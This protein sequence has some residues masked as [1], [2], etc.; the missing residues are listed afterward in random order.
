MKKGTREKP[1][2]VLV[3]PTTRRRGEFLSAVKRSRGLHR[4]WASPSSTREAFDSY[5]K[6]LKGP[7]SIGYWVRTPEDELAGVINISEVVRGAFSSAF[8]G[9]YAFVPHNGKGY[10]SKG[11]RAVLSKAF[12]FHRLHRLEANIQPN[13]DASR[14]LVRRLGFR[15]EGFSPRYLKL[16]G[17]WRD[18]ERWAI[19]AEEWSP[20][21]LLPPDLDPMISGLNHVQ[22]AM[23]RGQEKKARDFYSGI[24]GVPEVPKPTNLAKRGG[25]WFETDRVRIHLGID[26]DFRPARKAHPALLVDGLAQLVERLKSAGHEV[27]GDDELDGYGRVYVSDPFGNRLELTE[28]RHDSWGR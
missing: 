28:P 14:R 22:V 2:D 3:T 20:G 24:L 10:M 12:R 13:N 17:R 18:H 26:P 19:C 16:G 6:R 23:P 4:Q 9:Y 5:L 11:L 27:I 21:N 1:A 25:A 8:L 7:G 15:L